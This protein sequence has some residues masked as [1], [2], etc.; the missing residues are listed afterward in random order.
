MCWFQWKGTTVTSNANSL[1]FQVALYVSQ[2]HYHLVSSLQLF[3][4][5]FVP[6]LETTGNHHNL[7][8]TQ[9]SQFITKLH[10]PAWTSC[11]VHSF[12]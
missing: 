7:L 3:A 8:S 4:D 11:E 5:K 9:A 6:F 1:H 12:N 2:F 10:E